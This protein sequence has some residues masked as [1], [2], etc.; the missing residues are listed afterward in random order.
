MFLIACSR[1]QCELIVCIREDL[2]EILEMFKIHK[3]KS[4]THQSSND[5]HN[6][7]K[8]G[9]DIGKIIEYILNTIDV[10]PLSIDTIT[11]IEKLLQPT[12]SNWQLFLEG[13]K[14]RKILLHFRRNPARLALRFL[15]T[16]TG[17]LRRLPYS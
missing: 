6:L 15:M 13:E 4:R 11:S 16:E 14:N 1:A 9:K 5:C 8:C 17:S 12:H 2:E 3:S 10:Q 7:R